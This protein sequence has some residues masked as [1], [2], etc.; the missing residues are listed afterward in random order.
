LVVGPALGRD[1]T[2]EF[3]S[4]LV[5]ALGALLTVGK[6][7]EA[8]TGAYRYQYADLGDIVNATRPT[9]AEHGIAVRTPIHA[10]GDGLAVTVQFVH[11][12]GETLQDDPLPFPY[13]KDAQAT[14]SMVTYYR[15]YALLAALGM[16]AGDDDDGAKAVAA[17]PVRVPGFRSSVIAA[18]GKL[19]EAEKLQLRTWCLEQ[20]I[21]NV[22]AAMDQ[23]Q[24]EAVTDWIMA[25]PA[26]G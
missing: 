24:C 22:P 12:S 25:L 10:H 20:G 16:A 8:D 11:T 6:G 17:E 14:G 2:P 15:R 5:E 23:A 4:A 9:L 7:R 1:M 21:P 13:G 3:A 18:V 19:D 26:D